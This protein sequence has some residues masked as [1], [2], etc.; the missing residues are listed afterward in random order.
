MKKRILALLL[1]ICIAAAVFPAVFADNSGIRGIKIGDVGLDEIETLLRDVF[2]SEEIQS[3]LTYVKS[4]GDDIYETL[5]DGYEEFSRQIREA[6]DEEIEKII[7]QELAKCN[8]TISD[9]N[10][11]KLVSFVRKLASMDKETFTKRVEAAKKLV[12][13]LS[14]L[15]DG[16]DTASEKVSGV[17]GPVKNFFGNLFGSFN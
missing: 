4:L 8:V 17:L 10:A 3:I 15:S 12:E 14:K 16:L 7:R 5:T 11:E 2:S 9:D 1:I 6:S 13:K